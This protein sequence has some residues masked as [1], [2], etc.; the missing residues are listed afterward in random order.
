[1]R[2]ARHLTA[3]EAAKALGISLSTLYAYVSRGLVRSEAAGESKRSRRYRNEDVRMLAQRKELRR[4]PAKAVER[5][6]HWGQPVMESG[7]TL[8][9]DGRVYYRGLDAVSLAGGRTVEEVAALI[10]TGDFS[11]AAELFG[12]KPALPPECLALRKRGTDLP[13]VETFQMLLTP[14]AAVDA[15]AC[16]LR[17]AAVAQTGARILRLLAALT[18]N[19]RAGEK[20]IA[21]TIQQAL[22]P[23]KPKAA[24]LIDAALIL[25]ADH[26][27]NV[28]SFTARCVASAG[29]TPYAAVTAG[30]AALQGVKHGRATERVEAFLEEARTPARVR[31]V[32]TGRLKRGETIPGFGHPL[33][34]DGDPRGR[35]LLE[36]ISRFCPR[37]PAVAL[38]TKCC[39][40]ALD[41]IG[42][43][44][45]IDFGLT[46]LARA[47]KMPP[48]APLTIFAIGR[49]IGWIGH[50]I[51]EYQRDR[52]I[53][54]RARYVGRGPASISPARAVSA[55]PAEARN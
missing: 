14:A 48:G 39:A 16:D 4:D 8:I 47:L 51:E 45:T 30:L 32:M 36:L 53:R 37:S 23:G 31:M 10:W 43:R 18:V 1:M 15:A 25:C 35:A 24:R 44:P 27:L 9:T 28:S 12:S 3:R 11:F 5:A 7:I 38:A 22:A 26:E 54:P 49:T 29:S 34:P 2:S 41:L 52:I 21:Q 46:I 20:S 6:L 50:S 33:Y 42:E 13:A 55:P 40:A 19:R 17:P